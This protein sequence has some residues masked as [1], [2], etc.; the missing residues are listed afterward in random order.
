VKVLEMGVLAQPY[1]P[2]ASRDRS[3]AGRQN[4]SREQNRD[5]TKSR[6]REKTLERHKNRY[7]VGGQC[8]H[9]IPFLV[10]KMR[11]ALPSFY[12]PTFWIKPSLE[13][14]LEIG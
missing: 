1:R 13:R 3:L 10:E 12:V 7:N 9:Q 14:V 2:Q 4:R 5:L 11:F 8:K 6:S